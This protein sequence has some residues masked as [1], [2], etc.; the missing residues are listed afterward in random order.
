MSS[1]LFQTL[2]AS[3]ESKVLVANFHGKRNQMSTLAAKNGSPVGGKREKLVTSVESGRN[4]AHMMRLKRD[5]EEK[6]W[7][8]SCAK[9]GCKQIFLYVASVLSFRDAQCR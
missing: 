8:C 7:D 3:P 6:R 2:L 1:A 5:Q 4:R 9:E